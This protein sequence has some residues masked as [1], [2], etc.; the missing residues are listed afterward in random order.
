MKSYNHLYEKMMS[1]EN[2][3]SAVRKASKGKHNRPKVRK[4]C[5]NLDSEIPDIIAYAQNYRH[6]SKKPKTVIEGK[7]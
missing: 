3:R 7:K 6:R 5:E 1:E 4:L 2:V